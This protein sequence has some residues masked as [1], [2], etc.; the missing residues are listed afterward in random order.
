MQMLGKW[1][2]KDQKI[3]LQILERTGND[4]RISIEMPIAGVVEGILKN[5][6]MA[7]LKFEVNGKVVFVYLFLV[8]HDEERIE[9]HATGRSSGRYQGNIPHTELFKD[10]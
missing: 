4:Y 1:T 9:V 2:S 7:N 10:N 8:M 6:E 5:G 3:R